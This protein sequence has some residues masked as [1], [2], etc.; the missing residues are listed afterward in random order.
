MLTL[1]RSVMLTCLINTVSDSISLVWGNWGVLGWDYWFQNQLDLHEQQVPPLSLAPHL[2]LRKDIPM[3]YDFLS[4]HNTKDE[5][6][7]SRCGFVH[8]I[9]QQSPVLFWTPLTFIA[10]TKKIVYWVLKKNED[11]PF[12]NDMSISKWLNGLICVWSNH[13]II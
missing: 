6:N 1:R 7:I 4:F 9:S 12:W 10:W 2:L 13:L 5:E 8:K 11:E 3:M